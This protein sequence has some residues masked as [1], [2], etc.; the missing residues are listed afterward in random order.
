ME[1]IFETLDIDI[2]KQLYQLTKKNLQKLLDALVKYKDKKFLAGLISDNKYFDLSDLIKALEKKEKPLL[3]KILNEPKKEKD[4]RLPIAQFLKKEWDYPHYQYE[5]DL[6]N[7]RRKIDVVGCEYAKHLGFTGADRIVAIEIKT[8]PS[9][10]SIDSAFSQA[11]DYLECSDESYVAVS[12]YV[13]LK[14][15]KVL[16]KKV[17][18]YRKKIGLLLADKMRVISV[19]QEAKGTGHDDDKYNEIMSIFKK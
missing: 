18:S 19:I 6:P 7:T 3:F 1:E 12:P 8:K 14:Y 2:D 4:L 16:L 10:S 5:V 11:N 9:R 15:P 17:K 13:F